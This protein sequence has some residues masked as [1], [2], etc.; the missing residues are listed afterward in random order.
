MKEKQLDDGASLPPL[1][2]HTHLKIIRDVVFAAA[3]R[4][5]EGVRSCTGRGLGLVRGG[6]LGVFDVVVRIGR[7]SRLVLGC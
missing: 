1:P 6:R 3:R 7:R 4:A 5:K 2:S